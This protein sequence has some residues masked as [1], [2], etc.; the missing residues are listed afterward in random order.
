M[1]AALFQGYVGPP[2]TIRLW[3]GWSWSS[4]KSEKPRFELVIETPNALQA[5]VANPTELTLGEAFIHGELNIEGDIFA[6]FA[7][8]DHV[9]NRRAA[10]GSGRSK[11]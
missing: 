7:L 3:H 2:F 11:H 8:A 9:F 6:A 4:G 1:L 10:C 5:L